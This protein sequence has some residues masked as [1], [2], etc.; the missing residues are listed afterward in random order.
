MTFPITDA[1]PVRFAGPLPLRVDVVIIGGGI[2]GVMAAWFLRARGLSVLICE[3]GRIAGEQSSRNWG[4]VRQQGRDPDELPIMVESLAIWKEL[5]AELGGG[6]GFR[7]TGGLRLARTEAEMA[8]FEAWIAHAR[9]HGVDTRLQTSAEIGCRLKGAVDSWKGGLWTESDAQA[10]AWT[11]VPTLAAAAEARGVTIREACAVRV[12]DIAGGRVAGVVTEAGRVACDQVIVAAGS[13]SRLFLGRHGIH[14]PQLSVL[15]SVAATDP[16][17][18]IFSG[19]VAAGNFGLRRRRDGGYTIAP[20]GARQDFYIGSDAF[21]SFFKYLPVLKS[22]WR[23][24]TFRPM[25]PKGFPD[26]WGTP[27]QWEA[28]APG[29]FEAQRIL[30]PAPNLKSL[31][32]VQDAFARAFPSLGRPKLR[33]VWAGMIDTLPDVVPIL[34][35]APLSGLTIATGMSGHGFGI[36]PGFGRV[37]A[38]LVIGGRVGHDLSRFRFSRF[39]DG[40]KLVP[41]KGL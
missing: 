38:D 39:T 41:A 12:L 33:S 30:N 7:Q 10:D 35:H 21:R 2:I 25:A 19:C 34:D 36:G 18:E 15:G 17:P 1:S 8:R 13:W 40:S 3:K 29:P 14:I 32:A 11:A 4:W 22:E 37:L 6:L 31:G 27:R 5:A 24:T 26:A 20:R 28:D 23:Q 16:M 9:A